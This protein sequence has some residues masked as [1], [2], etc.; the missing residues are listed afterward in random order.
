MLS[1]IRVLTALS[2]ITLLLGLSN[3]LTQSDAVLA[4]SDLTPLPI[5]SLPDA[6]SNSVN[7][8]NTLAFSI[9]TNE[10][11]TANMYSNTMSIVAPLS[12]ELRAEIPVGNDPRSVAITPDGLRV[13]V[14]NR[15][16]STLSVVNITAQQVVQTIPLS[17]VWAYGVV[18]ARNGMAYVS[19]Q[20][21]DEVVV[22]DLN[23][24]NVVA[25]IPTLPTPTGLALWGDFLYV[26]HLWSGDISLIY[27]PQL[28]VVSTASTG[29]DTGM[30]VSLDIDGSRG[31]LYVPQTRS[32]V[33]DRHMSYDTTVFPV[34]NVMQLDDFV[35]QRRQRITLDTADRPVNMPFGIQVDP[36]RRWVFV[37]NAGSNSVSIIETESGNLI[38]N[39]DVGTNPRGLLLS[40]DRN[41]LFVHN[42]IDGSLSVIDVT[43]RSVI[44]DIPISTQLTIP[45]DVLI[46]SEFFHTAADSRIAEANWISCANCHL[47]GMSDGRVWQGI[48]GGRNTPTLFNLADTSPYTWTGEW[49]ELANVEMKIHN[50]QAGSG[51]LFEEPLPGV[52]ARNDT[53]SG[54]SIDLDSLVMYL[55][56]LQTSVSPITASPE[57]LAKGAE[58]FANQGCDG[59]H[60]LPS[61][62]S[63]RAFDVGTG[64]IF[65]TPSIIG[66]WMS[67]PYFHNGSA[68]TLEDVFALPGAHQ[69]N[70]V[71]PPEDIRALVAYLLSLPSDENLTN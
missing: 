45:I 48:A 29:H 43:A 25:R 66:L 44:D 31:M 8:S 51:L 71:I 24:G 38:A 36:F 42:V 60:A 68:A 55:N 63:L 28:K 47:D 10:I 61:G 11:V 6:R 62:T 13:L 52:L 4:Q 49:D 57:I 64:G 67:A 50:L 22:V 20:G 19:M 17:G 3:N 34:V 33:S 23:A 1:S 54:M 37:A 53:L 56:T 14:T 5:Y 32:N 18:A 39:I 30:S 12:G 40:T 46:G 41:R 26:T 2:L 70:M 65:D 21:S 16:D 7:T 58:I 15:G 69:L 59:C 35:L 27:L 9:A